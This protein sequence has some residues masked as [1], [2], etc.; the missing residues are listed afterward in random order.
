MKKE[1]KQEWDA[2]TLGIP[3]ISLHPSLHGLCMT[4]GSCA[5]VYFLTSGVA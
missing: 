1:Q 2:N 4:V 3:Y 5:C